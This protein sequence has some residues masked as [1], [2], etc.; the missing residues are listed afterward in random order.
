[1][2]GPTTSPRGLL[3]P[4]SAFT[5]K[6]PK[7]KTTMNK[8]PSRRRDQRAGKTVGRRKHTPGRDTVCAGAA[9]VLLRQRRR[10]IGY[11]RF[12]FGGGQAPRWA[13]WG[14]AAAAAVLLPLALTAAVAAAGGWRC[15][16]SRRRRAGSRSR[17]ENACLD[18][19]TAFV[20]P[21][22]RASVRVCAARLLPKGRKEMLHRH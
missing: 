1:V 4:F 2:R 9:L 19:F 16:R 13:Q 11:G 15:W 12:R 3:S 20:T 5:T 18:G 14:P 6:T 21:P 17:R 7:K 8:I 10:V 22:G